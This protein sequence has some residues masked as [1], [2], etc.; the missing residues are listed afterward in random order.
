MERKLTIDTFMYITLI[1][2]FAIRIHP[3]ILLYRKMENIESFVRP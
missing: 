1:I 3:S 2:N